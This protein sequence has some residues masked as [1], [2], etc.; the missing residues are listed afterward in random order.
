MDTQLF[1]ELIKI[2]EIET[3][4]DLIYYYNMFKVLKPNLVL[5]KSRGGLGKTSLAEGTLKEV[6]WFRGHVTP[7]SLFREIAEHQG[8]E[9]QMVFDDINLFKSAVMLGELKQITD[10][11]EKQIVGYNSTHQIAEMLNK[12]VKKKMS[13]LILCNNANMEVNPDL[14][15]LADRGHYVC[16]NPT[17]EEIFKYALSVNLG[18]PE[19]NKHIEQFYRFAQN[20]SLRTFVK[21]VFHF[22][23]GGDWKG[24]ILSELSLEPRLSEIIKLMD[25][26]KT[27]K[28]RIEHYSRSKSDYYRKKQ[29]LKVK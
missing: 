26:F 8:E 5:V 7:L 27:D 14:S 10:T 24:K 1:K 20:F 12:T 19:V 4:K 2:I 18:N 28:E 21:A 23:M 16:F 6:M 11:K 29:L 22:K 9:L 25:K 13:T 3:Y 17:N 15:A